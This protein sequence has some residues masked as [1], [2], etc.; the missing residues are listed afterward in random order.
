MK[1]PVPI[2]LLTFVPVLLL[3]LLKREWFTGGTLIVV[4]LADICF[5]RDV[6]YRLRDLA[7]KGALP[8]RLRYPFFL[9]GLGLLCYGGIS[10]GYVAASAIPLVAVTAAAIIAASKQWISTGPLWPNP[11]GTAA[12]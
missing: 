6:S 10:F 12:T 8:Y 1:R 9:V 11:R 5:F 2:A 7:R 3:A 4:V